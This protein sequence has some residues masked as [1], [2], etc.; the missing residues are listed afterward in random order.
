[1]WQRL[2]TWLNDLPITD[3]VD[4]R[5]AV[6]MQLLLAFQ[7]LRTPLIKIYLLAS[8][9]TYMTDSFFANTASGAAVSITI[10]LFT[11]LV[12]TVAAWVSFYWIRKGRFRRAV[13]QFLAAQMLSG[14][15][16]YATFGF[17]VI[18]GEAILII[19]LALGGLMLGRRA[20]WIIYV[21]ILLILA[22][23]MTSDYLHMP[24]ASRSV[25]AAYNNL[26]FHTFSYA[27]ITI[28]LDRSSGALRD[29]LADSD[30][31]RRL[32]QIEMAER[33]RTQEQLLHSQKM[34]AIGRLAQG[35]AHDF[36]NVLS[37]ILG[38]ARER[39][40]LDEPDTRPGDEV[41]QLSRALLGVETAA[42]QAESISRKLLNFSR[43]DMSQIQTIDAGQ[44]VG[45][46]QPLLRQLF[47]SNV[48]LEVHVP[49]EAMYIDID[50]SQFALAIL[51]V[52][53]N[54]RDAMPSGGTFSARVSR[55]NT[56]LVEIVLSDN[57]V[58][59]SE[60]T[61]SMI[62]EP[63][64]T[65]KPMDRGTGVG[66][67]VVY[68]LIRGAGGDIMVDSEV[69][70]GTAFRITLPIARRPDG[71]RL[72]LADADRE[73]ARLGLAMPG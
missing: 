55:A 1:M 16:A 42:K 40:C 43:R 57:G 50:A 30:R 59:M 33:E 58:G 12:I 32:L 41:R 38:F 9:W 70:Q 29:A 22:S 48:Q 28:I 31:H 27:L 23:G 19:S 20:L 24:A 56:E 72:A 67:T 14:L 68:N 35:V 65:T 63:Y 5:N 62:F 17:K 52:A 18:P 39:H 36:N 25:F 44:A 37:V 73:T 13:K 61:R 54:A 21:S 15:L 4:R 3:P 53:S 34:D 47:P 26:L 66:L 6:F 64:F 8:E 7:G 49:D 11:D 45:D 60:E 51:N 10:D 2:N 69:G 46:M 71:L